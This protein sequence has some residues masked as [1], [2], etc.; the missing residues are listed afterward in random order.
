MY[1]KVIKTT[2]FLK[3]R[4][5]VGDIENQIKPEKQQEKWGKI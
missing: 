3:V 1:W 2:I 4:K 5:K